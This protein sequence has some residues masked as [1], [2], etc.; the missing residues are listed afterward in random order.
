[1]RRWVPQA[2]VRRHCSSCLLQFIR[3]KLNKSKEC[4]LGLASWQ[5]TC[6]LAAQRK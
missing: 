5:L 2:G 4:S 1:M 3:V 6:Y